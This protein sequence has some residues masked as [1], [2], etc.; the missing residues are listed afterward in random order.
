MEKGEDPIGLGRWSYVTLR[1]KGSSK[2]TVI[3]AY[4]ASCNT[5]DTTNYCQQQCTLSSLHHQHNQQV[6]AQPRR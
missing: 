4:N 6:N 2:V 5:G 1:G 3:T